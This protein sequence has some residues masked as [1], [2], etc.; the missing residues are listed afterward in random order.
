MNE[1]PG[2]GMR[3]VL[4]YERAMDGWA[5]HAFRITSTLSWRSAHRTGLLN[6][7]DG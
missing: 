1:R 5:G 4:L 3:K 7:M 2:A 6:G